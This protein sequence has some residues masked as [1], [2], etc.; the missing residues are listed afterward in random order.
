VETDITAQISFGQV[1]H[2]VIFWAATHI[3]VAISVI[4]II[5]AI[6]LRLKIKML[7]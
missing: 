1:A 3:A 5:I 6:G 2:I 7:P 4:L